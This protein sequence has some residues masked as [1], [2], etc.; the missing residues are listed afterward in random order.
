[1][2]AAIL[3]M[4]MT[5]ACGS[6]PATGERAGTETAV[7]AG[8]SIDLKGANVIVITMDT[9]R[10]D[11]IGAYGYEHAETPRLDELA[12]EGVLFE[13][14]VTP[15][16]FTLP[17]HSSILTG[18]YPPFHGIRLNG[19]SALADVHTTM[20]ESLTEA[21]YRCGAVTAAFVVDGHWGLNQGFEFYDDDS[22][23]WEDRFLLLGISAKLRLL[24]IC[25][26]YRAS[27]S[28]IR[29]ISA[30]KATK[31]ESKFYRR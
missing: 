21:G 5:P 3:A 24:M 17:S 22:S 14:A 29:I 28:V 23:E 20:A 8:G 10:A 25:H 18:L 12:A 4:V 31:N 15:S 1:M 13:E 9:T 26:C 6:D 2:A 16:A 27:D 30:R 11:H 19:G 7:A